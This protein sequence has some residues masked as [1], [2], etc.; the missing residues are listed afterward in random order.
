MDCFV[1]MVAVRGLGPCR[2]IRGDEL[3]HVLDE[4]AE[5]LFQEQQRLEEIMIEE[6]ELR[7]AEDVSIDEAEWDWELRPAEDVL[8]DEAEWD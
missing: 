2:G 7:C 5:E 8:I 3:N 4:M 1:V 6:A